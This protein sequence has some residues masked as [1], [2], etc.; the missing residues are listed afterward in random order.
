MSY[1]DIEKQLNKIESDL[2]TKLRKANV[3]DANNKALKVEKFNKF[4]DEAI[5]ECNLILRDLEISRNYDA[6]TNNIVFSRIEAFRAMKGKQAFKVSTKETD[7]KEQRIIENKNT[8]RFSLFKRG[9]GFALRQIFG[10]RTPQQS[11][12]NTR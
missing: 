10:Q 11:E 4:I 1:I 6:N 5:D 3:I 8:K 9:K 12:E 7:G 2:E